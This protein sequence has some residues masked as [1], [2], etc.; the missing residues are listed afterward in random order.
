MSVLSPRNTFKRFPEYADAIIALRPGAAFGIE[1]NN[2][3]SLIWDSDT[4][5]GEAPTEA[6]IQAKLQELHAAWQQEQYQRLRFMQYPALEEQLALLYD[7]MEAGNIPGK[8]TSAWFAAIKSVKDQY[9]VGT[10]PEGAPANVLDGPTDV[11]GDV[12]NKDPSSW[13]G[14]AVE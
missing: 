8:D 2:Y 4:N 5:G 7:D 6:Q 9:P 14:A 11:V 13:T 12:E 10:Q 3:N 1:L